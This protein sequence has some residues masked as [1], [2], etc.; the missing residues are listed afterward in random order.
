[1]RKHFGPGSK[2]WIKMASKHPVE[3]WTEEVI[4]SICL[5]FYTDPV[6]LGCGHNFC[7]A[8]IARCWEKEENKSC[9]ECRAQFQETILRVNR[10]VVR[11]AEKARKLLLCPSGKES[12]LNCKE[13]EEELKLFC[14]TDKTLICL[15]CR[16]AREHKSHN[17]MPI[18]EAVEV[19]KDQ[20]KSSLTSLTEKKMAILNMEQQ[21]KQ[22]ISEIQDQ[23]RSLESRVSSEFTKIHQSLTEKEQRLIGDLKE[24]EERIVD[25]MERRLR[26]IREKLTSIEDEIS[27]LQQQIEQKDAVIFLKE[28]SCRKRRRVEDDQ[29]LTVRDGALTMTEFNGPLPFSV[30]KEMLNNIQSVSVTLDVETAGLWLEVSEDWKSVRRSQILRDLPDSGKRFTAWACVLGLEGFTSGRHYW[31]VE[32]AGNRGWSLGVA[33]ES[34]EREK[35]I[36]L[37]PENGFWTIGRW[38]DSLYVNTSPQSPLPASP[39]PGRV[40]VYLSYEFRTVSFYNAE[41]KTHLYTFTGNK[42]TEKLYPFFGNWD[43]NQ[44]LRMCSSS[45]LGL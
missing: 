17:F 19:C 8:C 30:W 1:M 31:E 42:F 37:I 39:I 2:C 40:G 23:S 35:W 32:V 15:I 20:M 13:H 34:V 18:K 16:D 12:R 45:A 3:S 28:E 10:V 22:R 26:E 5:D 44:W 11:L 41:S 25:L 7:R 9:P 29:I 14:E 27:M 6:S 4:C 24:Q 43:E 36:A 33:T 21:Q 38:S